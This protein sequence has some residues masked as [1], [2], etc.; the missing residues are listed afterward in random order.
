MHNIFLC[1]SSKM[2]FNNFFI[3]SFLCI[4]FLL[5]VVYKLK[6]ITKILKNN[7][8][9]NFLYS[10]NGILS[11]KS[12]KIFEIFKGVSNLSMARNDNF[13]VSFKCGT[14]ERT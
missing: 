12:C 5:S 11:T 7:R 10:K 9:K 2:A 4:T 3:N 14:G 13:T 8:S 6:L 1:F